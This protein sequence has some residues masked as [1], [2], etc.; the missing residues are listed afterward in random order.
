MLANEKAYTV[1][2]SKSAAVLLIAD[3][4]GWTL[5]NTRLLADHFA[6]E[7]NAT[8]FVPDLYV[9]TGCFSFSNHSSRSSV[10]T[11]RLFTQTH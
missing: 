11:A 5:N 8:V 4:Y 10:T 9:L 1:G 6:K 3:I 2:D 7:A